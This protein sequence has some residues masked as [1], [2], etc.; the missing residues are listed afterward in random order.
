MGEPSADRRVP[1][2]RPVDMTTV[3]F[4]HG[5]LTMV[6]SRFA[7]RSDD[8]GPDFVLVHGIGVS[9][10]TFAP[11]AAL[12]SARGTVHLID[13]PGHGFSPRPRRDVGVADHAAVIAAYMEQNELDHPVVVGHSMGTQVAA[14]LAF[15]RPDLVDHVVLIAPVLA[16]QVRSAGTALS[17]LIRDGLKE[18]PLVSLLAMSDYLFVSG[19][20]FVLKQA[21]HL[22]RTRIEDLAPGVEAL[23]LVICGRDDPIV[24]LAWAREFASTFTRGEFVTVS[25]PHV[26]MVAD[27]V[28]VADHIDEWAHRS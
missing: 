12:L 20:A 11:T 24:P 7:R 10:K 14:R 1:V 22:L 3:R 19:P 28:A 23:T 26:A 5:D 6:V 9:A 25:G 4:T 27:P 18:P 2:L 17:L 13:M 21:R 16:P 8:E 15:D